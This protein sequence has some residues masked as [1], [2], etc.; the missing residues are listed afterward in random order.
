MSECRE[1]F[2]PSMEITPH[3][4]LA[5]R[6]PMVQVRPALS[7]IGGNIRANPPPFFP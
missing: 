1:R 4:G 2:E 6:S 3:S 7:R 5:N